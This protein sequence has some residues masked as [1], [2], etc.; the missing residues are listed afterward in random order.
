MSRRRWVQQ[1][2]GSLIEVDM[3]YEQS[4]PLSPMIIGCGNYDGMRSPIDGA[5]ISTRTKHREYMRS[6]GLATAD[7]FTQT[8]KDAA[9]QRENVFKGVDPHR[10][11]DIKEAID[12]VSQGYK[13]VVQPEGE[14]K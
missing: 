14:L 8:W 4:L 11:H 5:D 9:V 7:D 3:S 6:K 12:K 2:D 1:K 10:I 13:P